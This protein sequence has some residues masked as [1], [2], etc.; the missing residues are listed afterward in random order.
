[1]FVAAAFAALAAGPAAAQSPDQVRGW[2]AEMQRVVAAAEKEGEL[3]FQSQPN[4]EARDFLLRE[5]QKAYPKIALQLNVI[6]LPQWLARVR[7]ERQADKYLW[8]VAVAGFNVAYPMSHEGILD[9]VLDEMIDPEIKNPAL[10]GGWDAAF[11]DVA[12][13]Y[14]FSISNFIAGPWFDAQHVPPEKVARLRI[15]TLL[16]PEYAGKIV[17]HDPA[18]PGS[19]SAPAL[20]LR[21]LL[22]NDDYKSFLLNQKIIFVAQQNQVVETM[23][24]G[25]AW[26]GIGPPVRPLMAQFTQAGVKTD[27]RPF[28]NGPEVNMESIGGSTLFVFNKRP[29]PNATKV[30]VNWLLSKNIQYGFAKAIQQSSRRMDVPSVAEPDQAPVAGAKYVSSPQREENLKALNEA[31]QL[32]AEIRKQAK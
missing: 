23:A 25:V 5:W 17:W 30:F 15:K 22:G 9:P 8:D 28:G 3:I 18:V 2:K 21:R 24:R 12:K 4:Q 31:L 16:D 1:L 6:P 27:I 13:K 20:M 19:G 26:I 10:W 7:T 29:H 11:A 14:V 32:T